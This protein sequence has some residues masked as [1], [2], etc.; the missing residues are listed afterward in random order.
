MSEKI[1]QIDIFLLSLLEKGGDKK[2]IHIE[3]IYIKMFEDYPSKFGWKTKKDWINYKSCSKAQQSAETLLE[4]NCGDSHSLLLK[5]GDFRMFSKEGQI[6][7]N[8]N[9]KRDKKNLPI[10][11]DEN[12]MIHEDKD[13]IRIKNSDVYLKFL[14]GRLSEISDWQIYDLLRL[15]FKTNVEKSRSKIDEYISK[16][17]IYKEAKLQDFFYE[18]KEIFTSI[19]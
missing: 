6:W 17:T 1:S 16:S 12:P 4:K 9:L 11:S 3:E 19:F 5:K 14:E 2:F 13:F 10:D 15:P 8:K 7:V 18:I